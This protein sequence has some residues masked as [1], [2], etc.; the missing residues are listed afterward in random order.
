MEGIILLIILAI[1][2]GYSK[3]TDSK[4]D[5]LGQDGTNGEFR[6]DSTR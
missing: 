6:G 5:Y 1:L 3:Y 2:F 4:L